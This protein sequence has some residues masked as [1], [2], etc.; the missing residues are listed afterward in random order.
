MRDSLDTSGH[1]TQT[2]Q[3]YYPSAAHH[4]DL[5]GLIE[6]YRKH[7]VDRYG[8]EFELQAALVCRDASSASAALDE[9]FAAAFDSWRDCGPA[10]NFRTW[11]REILLDHCRRRTA[12]DESA[13]WRG[14]SPERDGN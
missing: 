7:V 10:T 9:A 1:A 4:Q 11:F 14:D 5:D 12:G 6:Q 3:Q 8:P 13:E 2:L